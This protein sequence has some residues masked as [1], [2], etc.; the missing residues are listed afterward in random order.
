[1]LVSDSELLLHEVQA[2]A[3]AVTTLADVG[4]LPRFADA[5]YT[6]D[7]IRNIRCRYRDNWKLGNGDRH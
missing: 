1:M 5:E 7:P 3:M 4:Y 6:F 2:K